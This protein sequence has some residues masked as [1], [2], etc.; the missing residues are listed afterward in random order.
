MS[1]ELESLKRLL[2]LIYS[3]IIRGYSYCRKFDCYVKHLDD[4][5]F[6]L[7]GEGEEEA[8]IYSQSLGLLTERRKIEELISHGVWSPKEEAEIANIKKAIKRSEAHMEALKSVDVKKRKK[9]G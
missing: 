3:D 2:R 6:S 4:E 8:K 7:V 9:K 1:Q 5:T